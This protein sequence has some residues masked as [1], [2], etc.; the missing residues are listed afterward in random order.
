MFPAGVPSQSSARRVAQPHALL[1]PGAR[2]ATASASNLSVQARKVHKSDAAGRQPPAPVRGGA[3]SAASASAATGGI[4]SVPGQLGHRRQVPGMI[5]APAPLAAGTRA[6]GAQSRPQVIEDSEVERFLARAG[7]QGHAALLIENGFDDMETLLQIEDADLKDIGIPP[8]LVFRLRTKIQEAQGHG[9]GDGEPDANHPVVV[10]LE[11]SGLVQYA[12]LLLQN[13]F[14]EMETLLEMDDV[15][16]KDLGIARGHA[17][18][19]KK[20]LH[21]YHLLQCEQEQPKF[22]QA[23]NRR[24]LQQ[25]QSPTLACRSPLAT[26]ASAISRPQAAVR[27]PVMASAVQRMPTEQ[28]KS[29]VV[30]SWEK[31]QILGAV[32]VGESLCRHTFALA[33]EAVELFPPEVRAR[34]RSWSDGGEIS[35]SDDDSAWESKALRNLFAKVINAVGCT[36]AGLHDFSKLVPMLTRLGA[37]HLGYRVPQASWQV[38]GKALD[39]TL[40][41]ILGEAY[42][43]EVQSAWTMVYGFMSSIMIEGLLAAKQEQSAAGAPTL[44]TAKDTVGG[45]REYLVED[46]TSQMSST[47]G[48]HSESEV[49]GEESGQTPSSVR[50]Q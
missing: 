23:T 16:M 29:A 46:T 44:D 8:H 47:T 40:S 4:A 5:R 3:L 35:D 1:N 45:C 41:E 31:V 32:T 39:L 19:L 10:F 25:L 24:T 6:A 9:T 48:Y 13:G 11:S 27:A 21:E 34:Y 14:D 22:L 30:Q 38:V 28:A 7:L 12:R 36:V 20:R 49:W 50:S 18:K 2:V 15:D 17:L 43:Q 26:V 42:T 37:R 33:P